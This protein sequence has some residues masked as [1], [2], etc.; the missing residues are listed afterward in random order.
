MPDWLS[1]LRSTVVAAD[2]EAEPSSAAPSARVPTRQ[3]ERK[4]LISS[5][6][7]ASAPARTPRRAARAFEVTALV[8]IVLIVSALFCMT[9]WLMWVNL[10]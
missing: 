7:R 8:L 2:T 1:T 10:Q 3:R 9:A 5:P 4:P 6:D